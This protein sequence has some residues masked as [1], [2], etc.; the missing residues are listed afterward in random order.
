M[1]KKERVLRNYLTNA[2]SS[3]NQGGVVSKCL[4]IQNVIHDARYAIKY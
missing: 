3:K 1:S 4:W 2:L